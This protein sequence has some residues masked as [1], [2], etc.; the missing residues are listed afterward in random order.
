MNG[1]NYDEWQAFLERRGNR[2]EWQWP[3]NLAVAL[4]LAIF[5]GAAALQHMAGSGPGFRLDNKVTVNFVSLSGPG[6]LLPATAPTEP[7]PPQK[8]AEKPLPAPVEIKARSEKKTAVKTTPPPQPV[9]KEVVEIKPEPVKKAV[10]KAPEP[11]VAEVA[12]PPKPP[13]QPVVKEV[14]EIKPEPVK[15]A[16]EKAPEPKV[17]EAAPPK[18]AVPAPVVHPVKKDVVSLN[19]VK[20]KAAQEK[21]AAEKAQLAEAKKQ[22]ELARIAEAKKVEAAKT[23]KLEAEK[24][25]AEEKRVAEAQERK[26]KEAKIAEARKERERIAA[27]ARK[28]ARIEAEKKAAA[29]EARRKIAAMEQRKALAAA[30]QIEEEAQTARQAVIAAREELKRALRQNVAVGEAVAGG[31]GSGTSGGGLGGSRSAGRGV[32]SGDALALNIY[33]RL[34]NEKISSHW[35]VPEMVN[36]GKKLKTVVALVVSKNGTIEDM[37]IEQQSGDP[38]F[39]QSVLKAL[40][41]AAPLPN[42]PKPLDKPTLEFAL[43]FTP[44]GLTTL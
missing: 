30:K 42:F 9:V 35:K 7:A 26:E 24:K 31:S 1:I 32:G 23:A 28:T 2:S 25:A 3:L 44:Q 43:N 40:R 5:G 41:S 8:I 17:V 15:K 20:Q 4:H 19:P 37:K 6:P 34:L 10:E 11:K 39:D 18:P 27:E 36:A 16:V 38:L 14:A 33:G 21:E 12:P 13:A 29:A 22:E